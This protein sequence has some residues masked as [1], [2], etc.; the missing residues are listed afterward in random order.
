MMNGNQRFKT[1]N[2]KGDCLSR[3][4]RMSDVG[5]T[6]SLFF[7]SLI[8][9]FRSTYPPVMKRVT[10]WHIVTVMAALILGA[11]LDRGLG[12]RR[13]APGPSDVSARHNAAGSSPVSQHVTKA[14]ATSTKLSPAA[15]VAPAKAKTLDAILAERDL[16]QRTSDLEAFI[17]GLSSSDFADA[18][19]RIQ[20]IPGSNEREL[21][22]RLLVARWVQTDPE[23]ALNFASSN[24][25]FEYIADD[26]F[27]AE[28]ELD[29]Q[30]ALDRAKGI[31]DT[32]LRYMALRGVLSFIADSDPAGALAL[33]Q[34]LGDFPG[35]ESLSSVIYRQWASED[36]QGAAL[37]AMQDTG[38][39]NPW[40]SPINQVA[41]TW[42]A[43]DPTSAANW[44]ISLTD[45]E[46]EARSIAQV[47]RQWARDDLTAAANWV[48][49]LSPGSSYDAAAAAL[50]YSIGWNDP[51]TAINWANN[52]ADA[53]VRTSALQQISREVMWHDP[54]N[55]AA[56]LQAA[57]VPADLIP[58]PGQ[59]WRHRR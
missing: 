26:V 30:G 24:R 38:S 32:D 21:A 3:K 19:R 31:M 8:R 17:N 47:M 16:R 54:T 1:S 41:R 52:I 28:A 10:P 53:S 57:G 22:S 59:H 36:P 40:R 23:A 42:A 14:K 49:G 55:G 46:A 25:G 7:A 44:A 48:N 6:F 56:V 58:P 37:Q 18:L 51:Q 9:L 12:P 27:Q 29:V 4:F 20:K 43:Q 33:A 39:G 5:G 45:P 35:N 15:S 13:T 34:S 2:C 11:L 50:A